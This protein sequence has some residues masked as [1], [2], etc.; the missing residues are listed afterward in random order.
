MPGS[1]PMKFAPMKAVSAPLPSGEGWAFEIKWDG[2]RAI[3][4]VGPDG[5]RAH[6]TRG[7]DITPRF[8]ELAD[9]A[10]AAGG[11]TAV[12]DGELVALDDSGLPSFSRLQSR[13]HL[14]RAADIERRRIE[15]PVVYV[16]FDLLQLDGK[17]TVGLTYDQRRDLLESVVEPGPTLQLASV[18]REGGAELLAAVAERGMEG[19]VAKR[20]TSTY[21]PGSRSPDWVKVKARRR[22]EFVVGGWLSGDGERTGTIAALLLGY[23]DDTGLRFAGRVGSGLSD[24]LVAD[25]RTVLTDLT[26][27]DSPFVDPVDGVRGRVITFVRPEVVVEVEFG[28]WTPDGSLRHPAYLG[29]RAEVDPQDV[30]REPDPAPEAPA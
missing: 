1:A 26:A 16:V 4:T 14:D 12:L 30:V 17:N 3:T 9:L 28:E 25:L 21:Q 11:L 15:V 7:N 27:T 10:D 23:H 18:H 20:V 29:R 13:M 6:S 8:P 24:A 19:I 2:M 5:V 22:Q